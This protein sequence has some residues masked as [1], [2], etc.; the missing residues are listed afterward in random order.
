[1]QQGREIK[2]ELGAARGETGDMLEAALGFGLSDGLPEL[3]FAGELRG[4]ADNRGWLSEGTAPDLASLSGEASTRLSFTPLD[5][6]VAL[7]SCAAG[8]LPGSLCPETWT[9]AV[10]LGLVLDWAAAWALSFEVTIKELSVD[11]AKRS[12]VPGLWAWNLR[13]ENHTKRP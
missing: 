11:A 4:G 8:S 2:L 13:L 1:K 7:A 12:L 6:R 10:S 5:C 3:G 9:G